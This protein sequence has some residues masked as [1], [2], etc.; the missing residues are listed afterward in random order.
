M[1]KIDDSSNAKEQ[2]VLSLEDIPVDR[3]KQVLCDR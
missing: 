3:P 2:A 1:R